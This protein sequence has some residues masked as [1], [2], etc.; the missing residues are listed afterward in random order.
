MILI[1]CSSTCRPE[2]ADEPLS[3]VQLIPELAG[4][5][6]VT[7]PQ[8]VALLD[9]RKAV[10]MVKAM[11]IPVLGIVENM[12]G[13]NCPHCGESISIFGAGGGERMAE[14]MDVPFLGAIPIDPRSALWATAGSHLC[15]ARR[16]RAAASTRSWKGCWRCSISSGC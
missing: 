3:V 7:T 13:L 14:E 12:S 10:N 9:S 8:E 5:I 11:K 6:I 1:F 2:P 15:R 4:A 16:R